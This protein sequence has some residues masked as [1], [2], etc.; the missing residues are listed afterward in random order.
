MV[1]IRTRKKF[2]AMGEACV[3]TFFPTPGFNG[4]TV[5]RSGFST[6]GTLIC[7]PNVPHVGRRTILIIGQNCDVQ[8]PESFLSE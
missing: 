3:D 4:R 5:V 8:N 1:E 7:A 2:M 6:E